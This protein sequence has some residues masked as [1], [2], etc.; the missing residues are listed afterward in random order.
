[1]RRSRSRQAQPCA[2]PARESAGRGADRRLPVHS[3]LRPRR[4]A[5][6]V[7]DLPPPVRYRIVPRDPNAHLFEVTCTVEQPDREG[8]R[9]RLPCLDPR[10]LPDPRVRPPLRQRSRALRRQAGGHREGGQGHVARGSVQRHAGRHRRRVRLRPLGAHGLPRRFA[11]VLQRQQRLPLPGRPRARALRGRH[12]GR[13]RPEAGWRVATTLPRDGAAPWGFGRYRA[14]DYDEL[15]DHPG[16]DRRLRARR[17]RGRRR[18]ARRGD[19]RPA[20]HRPAPARGRPRA[21]LPLADRP[22]RRRTGQ[23]GAVRPLPVPGRGRRRRLRRARAPHEHRA[24]H[25]A[26]RA[27]ASRPRQRRRRLPRLPRAR[28]PRVLPRVERQAHQARLVPALR[29]RARGLHPAA[30]GLRG[31]HE[32][33]RRPRA[34]AQRRHRRGRRGWSSP[35]ARSPP[36]CARPDGTCRAWRSRASTRGSS[37]TARTRTRPTRWSATTRKGRSSASRST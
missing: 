4:R 9:L 34:G 37:T 24:R 32:L 19:Q 36:C 27:A 31:V 16:R 17:V 15:V 2:S 10:Q 23:P 26:H 18:D 22:L 1:M 33:L 7:P 28:E 30:V 29:S 13:R 20:R 21:H 11:R 5:R 35:A 14:A 25:L 3:P 6:S 12:R 8:Q